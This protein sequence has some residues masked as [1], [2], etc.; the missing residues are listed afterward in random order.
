MTKFL[1]ALLFAAA[2]SASAQKKET[3]E[4][5]LPLA[6]DKA[7]ETVRQIIGLEQRRIQYTEG[8]VS[9]LEPYPM[10]AKRTIILTVRFN[11]VARG[12]DSSTV[13][14]E[15]TA[16]NS[17]TSAHVP[18]SMSD[19]EVIIDNKRG[20]WMQDAWKALERWAELLKTQ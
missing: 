14:I 4:V 2:S 5:Q 7:T 17:A 12:A 13:V 19:T 6:A 20:G 18:M 15:G 1:V 10:A 9:G 3:I 11:V 8:T 16:R